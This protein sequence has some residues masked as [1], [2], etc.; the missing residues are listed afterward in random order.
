MNHQ[1][2]GIS[3]IAIYVPPYRV[4]LEK[5][6]EWTNQSWE[7]V[8]NV[9]GTGFRMM[10]PNQTVYTMAANAVLDLI[11]SHEIDSSEIGFL[12]LGTESSTDN[13]AGSIII[14]GMVNKELERR[15]MKPISNNCEVPEYKQAC[16]SGIYALKNAVRFI[17]TDAPSLK[18]IVVCSDI[19]LYQIGASGEPT[20][21]AGAVA[22]L[23]ES[24]PKIAEVRTSEAGSASD[25]R[26][27]DFRKPIQY[28][29]KQANG[30]SD[31]D[32]ELPIFNGKYSSSC[33]IDGTLNAMDNMSSKN[34]G[35]L[36]NHLRGIKAVFM[37]RPFKRMPITAFSITYLYALAHG[38]DA[39]QEELTRYINLSNL[40]QDKILEELL[41]KPNVSD[42]PETDINREAF[43]LTTE[44]VKIIPLQTIWCVQFFR[45]SLL[46]A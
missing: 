23:I 11:L 5:W 3:A 40:D 17:K 34:S 10:G 22:A 14:K 2:V 43:P 46:L 39:D 25:Y 16:L 37:H 36:A 42:F 35:H 45:C 9:I 44:L 19:A 6:C 8:E 12:A 32:L 41:N 27:L 28:R 29:A 20:Q 7:K 24:N 33:Y 1:K 18:G 38:D 30:H 31:F 26:H 21:G 4:D 13:S 15:S